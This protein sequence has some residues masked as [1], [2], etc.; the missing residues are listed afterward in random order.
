MVKSLLQIFFQIDQHD[1]FV[2]H[3]GKK[4]DGKR[5]K[6]YVVRLLCVN[7]L[8]SKLVLYTIKNHFK[9]KLIH[10]IL[11]RM[12]KRHKIK[13]FCNFCQ[14][15]EIHF[16]TLLWK[17]CDWKAER[18]NY[19]W[20]IRTETFMLTHDMATNVGFV[21]LLDILKNSFSQ[22]FFLYPQIVASWPFVAMSWAF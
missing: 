4:F 2:Y 15:I 17:M 19:T 1:R 14:M 8:Y 12:G 9:R 11:K 13:I 21:A 6:L 18:Q 16:F 22:R 5:R 7:S 10:K 20:R 3:L